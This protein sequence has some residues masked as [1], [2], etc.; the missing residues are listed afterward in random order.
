[1]V[2]GV[3]LAAGVFGV[4]ALT[5]LLIFRKDLVGVDASAR[6]LLR[7]YLYLASLAAVLVFA[8]GVGAIL[9]WGMSSVFGVDAIYGRAPLIAPSGDPYAPTYAQWL[10]ESQLRQQSDLLRG[11]TLMV[12]GLLFWGGHRFAR[13]RRALLGGEEESTSV[14]RRAYNLLGTF[15]FGLGT[16]V[17]LPVG[18]YQML[19]VALLTASADVFRQGFGDSLAGGLMSIPIWLTYLLRVVRAVPASLPTIRPSAAQPSPA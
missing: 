10:H 3:L 9:D 2:I 7:L 15:V 4:I 8:I 14:L 18:V 17:L 19:S 1:M 16:V 5:L 11:I 13:G 6:S 12:F